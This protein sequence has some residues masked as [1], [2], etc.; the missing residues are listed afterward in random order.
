[1][2]REEEKIAYWYYLQQQQQNQQYK[3]PEKI[4]CKLCH[5][6]IK[7]G[8]SPQLKYGVGIIC[9]ECFKKGSKLFQRK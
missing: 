1:M 7:S 3:P 6:E 5:K 2:N 8:S 4:Y 9:Y